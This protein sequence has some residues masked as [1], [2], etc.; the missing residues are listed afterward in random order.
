M[1]PIQTPIQ[2]PDFQPKPNYLKTIIFSVLVI[3]TLGLITY[4]IF[5][6]QKLQKQVLN[7]PASLTFQV[8]SPTSKPL[9]SIS[10]S[11]DEMEGWKTY[12]NDKF[13]FTFLYPQDLIL[14]DQLKQ[15]GD[16]LLLQNYQDKPNRTE[17]SNDFQLVLSVGKDDGK[18][19][20]DYPKLWETEL[21]KLSSEKI[22]VG[23]VSAIKGF[24]GQKNHAV[25]TVWLKNNGYLYTFQLSTPTSNT[26]QLFDQILS[27]FKFLDNNTTKTICNSVNLNLSLILPNQD[28]SCKVDNFGKEQVGSDGTISLRSSIFTVQISS[29]GRGNFCDPSDPD[30]QSPRYDPTNACT[31]SEFYNR[32]GIQLKTFKLNGITKEIFGQT[33]NGPSLS[34]TYSG[35]DTRDLTS[36][37]K[38]EII[39]LLDSIAIMK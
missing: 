30:P 10:I 31:I 34:I 7:P 14:Y 3:I 38:T 22:S 28:W 4:L 15:I 32:N 36:S 25:P 9:S 8:P 18:S 20:E 35:M 11:P 5:Q 21:G 24:S 29:L 17:S 33:N 16:N 13:G 19:L 39:N 23:N 12:E 1:D 26:K 2:I 6:N 37:E 27:T